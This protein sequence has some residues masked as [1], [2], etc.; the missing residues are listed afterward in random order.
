[1]NIDT[2]KLLKEADVSKILNVKV[3]TL[4]R[5][6]WSGDGPNFVKIGRSVRYDPIYLKEYI[7]SGRCSSTTVFG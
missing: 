3:T 6:R 4:R 2:T 7:E 1:M 5:W